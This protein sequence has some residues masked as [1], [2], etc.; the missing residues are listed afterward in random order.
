MKRIYVCFDYDKD[1]ALKD[2]LIGQSR[3]PETPFEII[4]HSLKEPAPENNWEAKARERIARADQVIVVV[5]EETY[6]APGVLKE[7]EIAREMGKKIVQLKGHKNG[8]YK[9]VKG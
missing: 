4:D 5:G 7:I 6:H 1:R 3:N 2:L 9:R 8:N